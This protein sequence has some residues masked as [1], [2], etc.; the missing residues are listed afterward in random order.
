MKH[1]IAVIN[2]PAQ[3]LHSEA[4]EKK[5]RHKNLPIKTRHAWH[6]NYSEHQHHYSLQ[7]IVK[8]NF[9]D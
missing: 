4:K 1:D 7:I 2:L 9:T 3:L 6:T 5:S 8:K